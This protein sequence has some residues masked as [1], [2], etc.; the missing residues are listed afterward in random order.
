M[1]GTALIMDYSAYERQKI[2]H[3]IEKAGQLNIIEVGDINQFKLLKLDISDLKLVVM[4]IVFPSETDGFNALRRI[5]ESNSADVPVIVVTQSDRQEL[6]T[7]ALRYNVKDY[8]IKPYQVK[9]LESSIRSLVHSEKSFRYDTSDISDIKLS[10][11]SYV[12]REIKYSKRTKAPLSL[13]L[14]T[15]LQMH[16]DADEGR[17]ISDSLKSSI[18]AIAARKA[19]ETLRAT[20]TI[21]LNND[22]DII[23]VL[24]CTDEPG[25]RLVCEKIRMKMEPEFI[26]MNTTRNEYIYPVYVTFPDDGESFQALMQ[27]AFKKISD[28]EMLERIV[29][30]PNDT[31]KYADKSYNRYRRW[32]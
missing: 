24:P 3:I 13:I 18:F 15:T 29:S 12:E 28:K 22:R 5:K 32:L 17:S 4:D 27:K 26:K 7:E 1:D 25:A 6:K 2:R 20:D 19:K 9:R 11:D 14:I 16:N 8:V 23:I 21:V 30:I 10:F 31:R